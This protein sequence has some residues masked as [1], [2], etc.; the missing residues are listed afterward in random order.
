MFIKRRLYRVKLKEM[1]SLV[2]RGAASRTGRAIPTLMSGLSSQLAV[3]RKG[4]MRYR[5]NRPTKFRESIYTDA[6]PRVDDGS[7]SDTLARGSVKLSSRTVE[8]VL[9]LNIVPLWGLYR[10]GCRAP[11]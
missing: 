9:M 4:Q 2:T 8:A 6:D 3:A 5:E 1:E 11:G 7:L 10:S